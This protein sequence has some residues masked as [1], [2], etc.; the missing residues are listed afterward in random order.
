MLTVF[1]DDHWRNLML[2]TIDELAAE[3]RVPTA[4]ARYWRH[5]GTG[6]RSI[7]VGRHVRYRR[8]DVDAWLEACSSGRAT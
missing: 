3:L 8:E 6:P 4:S 5:A 1:N 2:L 7:K